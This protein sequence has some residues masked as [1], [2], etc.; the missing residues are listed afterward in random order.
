FHDAVDFADNRRIARL[1]RFEQLDNA[2]ETARDVFSLGGCGMNFSE[3]VA[4]LHL[5]AI[6]DHQVGARGHEVLFLG[7]ASGI[8]HQ[9]RRLVFFVTW[10]KRD[11]ELRKARDLVHLFFD[12]D[13][14]LQILELDRAACFRENG[15]GVGIP[16]AHDLTESDR[17]AIFDSKARTI[18]HVVAFLFT[19]LFVD[20][21]DQTGPVHGDESLA[22]ALD[23]LQVDK[24]D[25][26]AVAGLDL[27]L[28]GN[29]GGRAADVEGPH[30][31]LRTRFADGLRRDDADSFAHLDE[32]PGG[33]VAAVAARTHSPA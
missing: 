12:G 30:S 10:G 18:D 29:A 21:G 32:A 16:F 20:D 19:V 3:H 7:A 4:G 28:F 27:G 5:V 24:L 6:S 31:E 11:D 2:R 15:E 22:A 26:A 25:E 17:L 1:S 9:N 14:W 23:H 8:A 13:A 33:E